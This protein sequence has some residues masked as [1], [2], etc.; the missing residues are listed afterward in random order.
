ML[1]TDI[2]DFFDSVPLKRL[3]QFL[4]ETIKETDVIELIRTCCETAELQ[5]DGTLISKKIGLYQGSGLS[6][7]LSNIYLMSFDHAAEQQCRTYIRYSDDILILG[8]SQ[9]ELEQIKASIRIKLEALG[10]TMNEEKTKICSAK[11]GISFL[12][13]Q[14]SRE[15]AF[16]S[17]KG[18]RKPAGTS[19]R[20]MAVF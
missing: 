10:L 18:R 4:S 16:C 1:K 11:E 8:D 19:G 14:L 20:D 13:Y 7:V 5:K 6:P 12:G 15:G 2:K 9:E 17:T 3:Y